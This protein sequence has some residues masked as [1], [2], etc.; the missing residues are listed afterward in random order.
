M[1]SMALFLAITSTCGGTALA[2]AFTQNLEANTRYDVTL[3]GF[4]MGVNKAEEPVSNGSNRYYWYAQAKADNFDVLTAVKKGIPEWDAY[5][6]SAAQLTIYDSGLTLKDLVDQAQLSTDRN[7]SAELID[8]GTL[9]MVSISDF[10]KQRA[11]LG[12]EPV[13]LNDGQFFF[14]ADF[15]QL[16]HLYKDFLDKRTVLEVGGVS[17][18]AARTDLETMPRQTSS[19]ANN[20]G[21]IVVPDGL[22]T[23]K[24]PMSGFILNIM[25]NGERV[26]VEPA[27]LGALKKAFPGPTSLEDDARVWPFVTE[28]TA[29]GMSAQATGLTAMIAYLAVYIGFILLITCAAILALQQLSEAADNVSRYHLLEEIGVD[30]KMTGKA[31]LVQIAIYFLFPLVV[32]FCHSLE[33]LNVVVDVASM[34]G[35]LEIVMPLLATIGVFLVL[36]VGYFLFTFFASRTMLEKKAA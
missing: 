18:S 7:L 1:V 32:A 22:I 19:L 21:T 28:I 20:T 33:A 14:W 34:Y 12:L 23:D 10:N 2:N 6:K 26:D 9:S 36:Y 25:Y 30:R 27:F 4:T 35:H 3:T 24:T 15:E 29:L 31:L 5:V 11:L 8:Q 17:L 13:S 16:K